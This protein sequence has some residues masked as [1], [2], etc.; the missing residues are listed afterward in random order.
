[1]RPTDTF[2][3]EAN[4]RTYRPVSPREIKESDGVVEGEDEDHGTDLT[5]LM[6]ST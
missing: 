1:M 2:E 4:A 6:I 3:A 5:P